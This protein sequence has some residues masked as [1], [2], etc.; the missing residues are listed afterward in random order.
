MFLFLSWCHACSL[1]FFVWT[2]GLLDCCWTYGLLVCLYSFVGGKFE[3]ASTRESAP[4]TFYY[5]YCCCW[6]KDEN[7]QNDRFINEKVKAHHKAVIFNRLSRELPA[8]LWRH[9]M[10]S[11]SA[12]LFPLGALGNHPGGKHGGSQRRSA[13]LLFLNEECF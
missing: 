12:P 6:M 10:K 4:Q 13:L 1:M 2:V 11:H 8:I 5:Y 9:T 3:P 7:E